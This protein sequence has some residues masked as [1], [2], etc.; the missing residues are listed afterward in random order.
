[1]KNLYQYL[2][3]LRPVWSL[4]LAGA[5]LAPAG[6]AGAQFAS[7]TTY[8]TGA[9]GSLYSIAVADLNGD[10]R[11]DLLTANSATNTA[12]VSAGA[13]TGNVTVTT[14]SGTSNGVA[15]TVT[16]SP[17]VTTT[18]P[19]SAT[20]TTATLGGDVTSD[21][22]A[23][24][25]DR[26]VVYVV[27]SGTPTIG[28]TGVTKTAASPATGTGSYPISATG[29]LPSTTYSVRA[30]AIN[31][32]GTSYGVAQTFATL[33]YTAAPVVSSPA[34]GNY[35]NTPLPTYSGTAPAG[36]TVTVYVDGTGTSTTADGTFNLSPSISSLML[37]EGS[38]TVYATA[39]SSGEAVSAPS[40]TNTFIVDY[41]HPQVTFFSPPQGP[42]QPGLANGGSTSASSVPL[43]VFFSKLVTGFDATDVNVVN[44]SISNFSGS[45]T[46][47]SFTVAPILNGPVSVSVPANAAQDVSGLGNPAASFSFIYTGTYTGALTWTGATST[48][49]ATATNWSPAQV[50]TVAN[51]VLIPAAPANQ[52]VVSGVQTAKNLDL[53]AGARL[54]LA[55]SAD[56]TLGTTTTVDG[57][58]TLAAGSTLTQGAGSELYL[59]GNLTNNGA[60]FALDA[61]SE[62]G[63]GGPNHLLNGTTG[64]ELQTLTVGER[65]SFDILQLQVPVRIRRK[66]GVYHNS[67]TYQGHGGSLTLLSDAS[68]TALIENGAVSSVLGPVTIQRYLDP[69]TSTGVTYS[70][71][72]YRHYSSPMNNST[73][74]DLAT[75]GFT[76]EVSQASAYNGSATPGTTPLFPTVFGYDQSRVTMTS[77]YS[78]FDRG[79]VV[80]ASLDAP[81]V[82]GRGYA[83]QIAGTAKVDFTG[84]PNTGDINV[85]LARIAGN[86]DAGWALVGNPYPA[87]LDGSKLVSV[88]NNTNAPGLDQSFYV[89]ESTGPY[90]GTYRSYAAGFGGGGDPLIATGQGFFVRVNAANTSGQLQFRDAQRV[91][92]FGTQVS[93]HRGGA[94]S[95]Q[96]TVAL[97]MRGVTG[98]TDKLY[99]YADAQATPAFDSKYDAWKLSNTT[100]LNLSSRTPAAQDLSID[101]RPAFTATT[102]IPLAVGVPAAGTY[103]LSAASLT[104]LPVGL[105]PYL[106]DA[107]TGKTLKLAKGTSYSFSV[108]AAQAQALLLGR[109]A[110]S[111]ADRTALTSAAGVSAEQVGVYPNPATGRFAV[112]LPAVAGTRTLEAI[113]FNS[114]GQAVRRQTVRLDAGGTHFEV[115]ADGLA[116]GVYSL[117]LTAGAVVLTKRVV[118]Q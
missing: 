57:N 116:A 74:A 100:G 7:V 50:P 69:V 5:L 53:A 8:S 9:G 27:G 106:S 66:L 102:R 23:P 115:A 99:V 90:A 58:L 43:Q 24:V 95:P 97:T 21:G 32:V 112:T 15:F 105:D 22:G 114:L 118:L 94:A 35:V 61:T 67:T 117:R 103:T 38:H 54:S 29:L 71:L 60:T 77:T 40:A 87:P 73:V 3:T 45:G 19:A 17:T 48:D 44:G 92:T 93:M 11:P 109:F 107:A 37:I 34:N 104:N 76:P 65:G 98:P 55:A 2:T 70:G 86:A 16:T 113:L 80:P 4:A 108:S 1:M 42:Q 101:G 6:A 39:Q 14:P 28:G 64:V 47:F 20:A 81:L 91:T 25:T 111:F 88:E 12:S 85:S 68:G 75:A 56:L 49:W 31:S 84:T 10:G 33:A 62:V 83:V 18:A 30:Y 41:V 82:S 52:P 63:F 36:S 59:V 96:P 13:T 89:V 79:F 26:G 72:G 46:A 110:L 78:P 51:D